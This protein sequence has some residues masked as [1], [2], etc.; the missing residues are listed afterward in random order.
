MLKK[1][2]LFYFFLFNI[3]YASTAKFEDIGKDHWAYKSINNLL[4]RNI[5]KED[6][7][8]FDGKKTITKYEFV[9]SLSKIL[10]QINIEKLN[11]NDLRT[12]EILMNQ[13]SD[14]LNNIA[15]DTKSYNERLQNTNDSLEILKDKVEK[16]EKVIEDLLKKIEILEK[17]R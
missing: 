5:I 10:E 13:F 12:F 3:M 1:T 8:K 14:E 9:Y 15:F 6:S 17:R 4:E 11:Q 2:L 7:Y 16:N